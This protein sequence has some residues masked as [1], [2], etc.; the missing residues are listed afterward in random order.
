MLSSS[1][2]V[3]DNY[4]SVLACSAGGDS[5]TGEPG[6][7]PELAQQSPHIIS[8]QVLIYYHSTSFRTLQTF[9]IY[10]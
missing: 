9:I 3:K 1:N 6:A 2:T 4:T 8:C 5:N 7:A 10:I